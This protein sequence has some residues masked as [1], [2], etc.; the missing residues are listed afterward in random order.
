ME[1]INLGNGTYYIH[2]A[3]NSV[4]SLYVTQQLLELGN[5]LL[6]IDIIWQVSNF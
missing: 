6:R 1:E 5:S 3:S 2:K 4:S